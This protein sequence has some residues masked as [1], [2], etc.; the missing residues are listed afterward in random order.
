MD[1]LQKYRKWMNKKRNRMR[2]LTDTLQSSQ[3]KWSMTLRRYG[4]YTS[5]YGGLKNRSAL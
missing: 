1:R 5:D 2:N 4:K 3:V